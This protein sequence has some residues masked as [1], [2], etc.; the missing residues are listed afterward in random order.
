MSAALGED[1]LV[2]L[3]H[4][5]GEAHAAVAQDAALT[6]DRDQ[7]REVQ[8]LL[9]VSLGL[10]EPRAA[11]APAEG[12][13]LERALA[14]PV[15]HR[16]VERVVDEQEFDDRVLR[17][18]D[19]IGLGVDDHPVLDRRRA[20]GLKL[21]DP[22]DLDQAHPAGAHRVAEL[23]LVAEVGDLDVALLGRVHEHGAL[24]R[25]DL[26]AVDGE[27]DLLLLWAWHQ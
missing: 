26:A 20:R 10:D 24:D 25:F 5:L 13:V 1:Q 9:E 6:V 11:E 8:R 4:L 19:P 27:L 12:D 17:V 2:V 3:G 22:L 18:P 7:R 16:A 14:A 15:A 23:G 21:G